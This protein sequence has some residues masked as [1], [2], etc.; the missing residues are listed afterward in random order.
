MEVDFKI[1]FFIK[2]GANVYNFLTKNE[3][4]FASGFS[5]TFYVYNPDFDFTSKENQ[6]TL[7][8]FEARLERCDNCEENWFKANTLGSWYRNFN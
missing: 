8:E 2:E 5:P 3:L 1:S 6:L 7:L 4:Y